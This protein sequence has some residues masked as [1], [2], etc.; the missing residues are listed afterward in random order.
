MKTLL[1]A[2]VI[3]AAAL[4]QSV[5][6]KVTAPSGAV[7][8]VPQSMVISASIDGVTY[9]VTVPPAVAYA[10]ASQIAATAYVAKD[11]PV[12]YQYANA[13]D[14]VVKTFFASFAIPLVERYPTPAAQAAIAA[15]AAAAAAAAPAAP[16]IT[17]GN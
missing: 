11:G 8:T 1:L 16:V 17:G 2:L 3:S 7:A 15:A 6:A 10:I 14:Y 4:A 12:T 5:P 9:S 13:F